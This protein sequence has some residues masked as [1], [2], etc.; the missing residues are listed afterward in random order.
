M[1][2][3]CIHQRVKLIVYLKLTVANGINVVQYVEEKS[4]YKF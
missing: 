3:T 4:F 2:K 1:A